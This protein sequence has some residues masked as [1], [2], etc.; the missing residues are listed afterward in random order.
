MFVYWQH[1]LYNCKHI[2]TILQNIMNNPQ[3][4]PQPI[5]NKL[6]KQIEYVDMIESDNIISFQAKHDKYIL[7]FYTYLD[8][9]KFAIEDCGY[10]EDDK[11]TGLAASGDQREKM[12]AI[13]REKYNA[14]IQ[15]IN[16]LRQ[17]ELEAL[18]ED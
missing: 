12:N 6:L 4:L 3:K 16:D 15:H 2:Q 13:L 8:N 9:Y 5:F 10:W 18:W 7:E 11:W 1:C 14:H 17:E